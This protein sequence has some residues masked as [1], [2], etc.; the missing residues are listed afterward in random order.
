LRLEAFGATMPGQL[1]PSE[2]EHRPATAPYEI[3]LDDGLEPTSPGSASWITPVV[4]F[5]GLLL[6]LILSRLG[7]RFF[8]LPIILPFGVGGGRL[9]RQVLPPTR[10]VLRFQ[11]GI[12]WLATEG[13]W[14]SGIVDRLDVS[15]GAFVALGTTGLWLAG[16][17]DARVRV[18][19]SDGALTIAVRGGERARVLRHEITEMFETEGVPALPRDMAL[20]GDVWEEPF[21]NGE[22][23]EW[24]SGGASNGFFADRS[25]TALRVTPEAWALRV[26]AA[27]RPVVSTGGPGRLEARLVEVEH[28]GPLGAS[29]ARDAM[30]LELS[31][32]GE[33]VG[34]VGSDL[35]EPELR[36]VAERIERQ[37]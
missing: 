16:L 31:A 12:L 24:S 8:F 13:P 19:S 27:G 30:M 32:D 11:D 18:V 36:W 17:E 35:S 3:V 25:A 6:T 20:Q 2:E 33:N 21:E 4:L 10:R 5:A 15:T 37:F 22:Q 14:K 29:V 34:R 7:I 28:S 23:I 1:D 26:R 9:L